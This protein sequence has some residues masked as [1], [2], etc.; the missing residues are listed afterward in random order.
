MS[1]GT[2]VWALAA[3][4]AAAAG[5]ME[6]EA[7]RECAMEVYEKEVR[8]CARAAMPGDSEAAAAWAASRT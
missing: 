4:A 6:K 5:W 3:A 2:S 1:A 7:R 8:R